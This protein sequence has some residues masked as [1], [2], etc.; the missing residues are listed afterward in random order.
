ML[1]KLYVIQLSVKVVLKSMF[2]RAQVRH[3][4]ATAHRTALSSVHL[5]SSK[6]TMKDDWAESAKCGQTTVQ[7]ILLVHAQMKQYGCTELDF[8]SNQTCSCHYRQC[9][10]KQ[11][12]N[13]R[14]TWFNHCLQWPLSWSHLL[15][16]SQP[17][18]TDIQRVGYLQLLHVAV[19]SGKP[20]TTLRPH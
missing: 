11:R 10:C 19:I 15:S 12:D 14:V 16:Q 6:M 5:L 13:C 9:S 7:P 17:D 18:I 3:C 4:N 20:P 1:G 2:I 8:E